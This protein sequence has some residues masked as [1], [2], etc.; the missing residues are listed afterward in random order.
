MTNCERFM[1]CPETAIARF[2]EFCGTFGCCSGCPFSDDGP[3]LVFDAE[4]E[5]VADD[6]GIMLCFARWLMSSE[7]TVDLFGGDSEGAK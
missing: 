2:H 6:D 4:E 7:M 5:V 1:G 3:V